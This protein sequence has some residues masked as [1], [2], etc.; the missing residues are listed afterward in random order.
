MRFWKQIGS[1]EEEVAV[2]LP[3]LVFLCLCSPKTIYYSLASQSRIQGP[4]ALASFGNLLEMQNLGI[5][6]RPT[7]L[8]SVF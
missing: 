3:S 7:E 1:I 6:P 5:H 4:A 2:Q 8:E